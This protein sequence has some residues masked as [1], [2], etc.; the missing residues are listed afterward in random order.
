MTMSRNVEY[1][2]QEYF[3]SLQKIQVFYPIGKESAKECKK[4]L[5]LGVFDVARMV[6]QE[7]KDSVN[8]KISLFF[9][10]YSLIP[11]F[12]YENYHQVKPFKHTNR[13]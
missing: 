8:D 10:D 3:Y 9:E 6:F 5:K 12:N 2:P 13:R 7:S 1:M 4:D 11:K